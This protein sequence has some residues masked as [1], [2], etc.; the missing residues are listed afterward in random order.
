MKLP[1]IKQL[2]ETAELDTL[3]AAENALL[4]EAPLPLTVEGSDEGEQLTHVL[5]AI[6]IKEQMAER[7]IDYK[8]ALREYTTRVRECIN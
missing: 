1:V 4:E 5:A 3:R 8:T 2:V 7:S 6:W